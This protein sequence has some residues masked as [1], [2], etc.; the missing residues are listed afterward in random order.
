MLTPPQKAAAME[1][2]RRFKG[3]LSTHKFDVGCTDL[4]EFT[5]NTGDAKPVYEKPRPLN[6]AMREA[7]QETIDQWLEQ[8]IIAPTE[9][10]WASPVVPVKKKEG[11]W[12]FTVDYRRLNDVTVS[13]RFPVAHNME[14]LSNEPLARAKMFIGADLAGAYLA[15][16]VAMDSQNK[17]AVTTTTGLYKFLRMPFGAK[18]A[19]GAY[20]RLMKMVLGKLN[21]TGDVLSFFDDHLIPGENFE[22]LLL[23]FGRFLSA[24]EKANLRISPSKTNLFTDKVDWLGSGCD[25]ASQPCP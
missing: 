11:G 19:C 9:S 8:R 21:E 13:D 16:P 18:N 1:L 5:V 25:P 23:R 4:I 6:P 20:A 2:L 24:I 17:L 10:E 7:L 22:Q 14:A 3:V 12:R 15:V